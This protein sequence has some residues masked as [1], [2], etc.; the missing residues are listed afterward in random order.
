MKICKPTKKEIMDT[1]KY[2]QKNEQKASLSSK[3]FPFR[4]WLVILAADILIN[5]FCDP[6]EDDLAW[7]P[8]LEEKHV[9]NEQ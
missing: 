2:L 8:F 4:G 1:L 9:A 7:S 3:T 5:N 6:T